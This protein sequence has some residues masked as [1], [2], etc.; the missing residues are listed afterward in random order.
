MGSESRFEDQD[1]QAAENFA[2][3][4]AV[5]PMGFREALARALENE[6]REFAEPRRSDPLSSRG[7]PPRWAGQRFGERMIDSRTRLAKCDHHAAF[8]VIEAI[9]GEMGCGI[10]AAGCGACVALLIWP[11]VMSVRDAVGATRAVCASVT[12]STSGVWKRIE[13]GQRLRL[14]AEMKLPGRA[15][16]QFEVEPHNGSSCRI[17]Q[18]AICDPI[19]LLGQLYWYIF[20]PLRRHLFQGMIQGLASAA[21]GNPSPMAATA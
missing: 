7:A 5:K 10:T 8:D 20:Y 11:F 4:F 1:R 9:G 2:R 14:R 18:A 15:W 12:P 3:I 6:D 17:V 21:E 16:L 13:P 19:G